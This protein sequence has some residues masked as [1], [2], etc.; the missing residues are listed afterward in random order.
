MRFVFYLQNGISTDS[1]PDGYDKFYIAE[2]LESNS[3]LSRY[4]Y[5]GDNVQYELDNSC[6][7]LYDVFQDAVFPSRD[8]YY[9]DYEVQP[10]WI[11][12]A[13]L[14]S[15]FNMSKD[16]L[17][18][19]FS[20]SIHDRMAEYGLKDETYLRIYKEIDAKKFKYAYVA[21]CQSLVNTLQELVMGCHS[22]LI[23]FYK[24][25]CSL[26]DAP[27]M[28]GIYYECSPESRMV[29]GFLYNFIIQGYSAFDILT[30]IA[31]ELDHLRSCD[32]SYAKLA[33]SGV[34]YKRRTELTL[35]VTGTIFEKCRTTAIIEN[36]RNELIH[37]ATWEMNPKIFIVT[38]GGMITSR[39]IF[40]PD[41]TAEGTLAAFK[42]RKRFF[43]EGNKVNDELP[44]LY[45]DIMQRILTTLD[46]LR[47]I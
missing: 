29:Y 46:R 10:Q 22:S 17:I 27:Q 32:T 26:H 45:F 1:L 38:D 21:D 39:H 8:D 41:L 40:F 34:L 24:Y 28:E 19:C 6:V 47:T 20:T 4:F 25:L 9:K 37:N 14:D 2:D 15:D 44:E 33:S 31:Y 5:P 36:L 16:A 35:D 3:S 11:S 12:R 13:G 42:N 30:K 18:N 23:G 7:R 43:A